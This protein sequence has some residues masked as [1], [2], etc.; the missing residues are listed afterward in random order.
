MKIQP[1]SDVI[2]SFLPNKAGELEMGKFAAP[3]RGHVYLL[4]KAPIVVDTSGK[5]DFLPTI[6]ALWQAPTLLPQVF[7]KHPAVSQYIIN[8]AG[9]EGAA[10]SLDVSAVWFCDGLHSLAAHCVDRP[11]IGSVASVSVLTVI[12]VLLNVIG[13]YSSERGL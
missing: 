13:W 11:D 9:T 2:A 3:Q 7:L 8:G 4:D 12:I 6:F 1:N 5:G 10:E